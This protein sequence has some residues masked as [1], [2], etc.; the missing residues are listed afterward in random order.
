MALAI[1]DEVLLF[2][3]LWSHYISYRFVMKLE[4]CVIDLVRASVQKPRGWKL[5]SVYYL[6]AFSGMSQSYELG[7][8][9]SLQ[10][11]IC[12][13]NPRL[14]LCKGYE[15]KQALC[16]AR[17]NMWTTQ[18]T[19]EDGAKNSAY[20]CVRIPRISP[21]SKHDLC[22]LFLYGCVC[23]FFSYQVLCVN[24]FLVM[25]LPLK[26]Y[27]FFDGVWVHASRW[28]WAACV[29]ALC[30]VCV[31]VCVCV[32]KVQLS[33]PTANRR[34]APPLPSLWSQFS[35]RKQSD[36]VVV[37]HCLWVHSVCVCVCE[38]KLDAM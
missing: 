22:V 4:N 20:L 14:C 1:R 2:Y 30:S 11:N 24:V 36:S 21:R 10:G 33:A 34:G 37:W 25:L 19:S 32:C 16:N 8:I 29:W 12:A 7:H 17:G 9:S 18:E 35:L 26:I 23:S 27:G 3:S 31:C 5:T 28:V 38:R 13:L 6:T 15:M